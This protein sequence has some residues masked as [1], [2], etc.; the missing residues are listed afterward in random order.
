MAMYRFNECLVW[1]D[2]NSFRVRCPA[3]PSVELA[4]RVGEKPEGGKFREGA[5]LF[6]M[7]EGAKGEPGPNPFEE[8][9]LDRNYSTF[10]EFVFLDDSKARE[11]KVDGKPWLVVETMGRAKVYGSMDALP[12]SASS[13][14]LADWVQVT[15]ET[16]D[17]FPD[18]MPHT[19]DRPHP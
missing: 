16:E 14:G 10:I 5:S 18:P 17:T 13:F 6:A 19:P 4:I 3:G 11:E 7:V 8:V 2:G 15:A 12:V 9:K 1:R